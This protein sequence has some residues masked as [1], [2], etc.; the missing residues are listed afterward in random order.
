MI[1]ERLCRSRRPWLFALLASLVICVFQFSGES[2]QSSLRYSRAALESGEWYRLLSGHWV[3][4]DWSHAYM[5]MAGLWLLA[6]VD[7]ES[8][9][10]RMCILRSLVL[11]LAVGLMLYAG[12]PG[13]YWYVGL[14]GVLHGLFTIVLLRSAWLQRDRL[15]LFILVVLIGKLIWEH[16]HGA[17]TQ[18]VL[19]APVIVSAHSYGAFAGMVYAVIGCMAAWRHTRH[20]DHQSSD[21]PRE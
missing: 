12:E 17:L 16:Y 21:N 8:P 14:S 13:L 9:G 15:A 4:L 7:T 10:L 6:V 18:G 20:P 5:N 11:S 3:H 1:A 19:G 2:L